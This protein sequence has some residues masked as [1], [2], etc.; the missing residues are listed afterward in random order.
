MDYN[1]ALLLKKR[2]MTTRIEE[3]TSEIQVLESEK[4]EL[5]AEEKKVLV[6]YAKTI[7][8]QRATYNISLSGLAKKMGVSPQ[9]CYKWENHI[10]SLPTV[11]KEQL[12]II[13]NKLETTKN[14]NDGK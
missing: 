9:S 7:A 5:V 2:K 8:E 1:G 6:D 10:R 4:R 11:R 12:T 3:I 13:F 14:E